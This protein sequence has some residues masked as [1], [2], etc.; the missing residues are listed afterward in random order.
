MGKRFVP[1]RDADRRAL[2]LH[3]MIREI[4]QMPLVIIRVQKEGK[5]PMFI[6]IET[7]HPRGGRIWLRTSLRSTSTLPKP[8]AR[9]GQRCEVLEK[10]L[11]QAFRRVK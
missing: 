3:F 1:T 7:I 9:L 6:G 10:S 8:T 11:A 4:E 5:E 2:E